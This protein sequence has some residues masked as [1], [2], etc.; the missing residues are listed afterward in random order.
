LCELSVKIPRHFGEV[1]LLDGLVA[2]VWH[3][4]HEAGEFDCLGYSSLVFVAKLISAACG[5][6]KLG[7][8][9]LP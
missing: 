3:D 2:S 9:I 7:S 1:F 4:S 6:L 5:N 8:D